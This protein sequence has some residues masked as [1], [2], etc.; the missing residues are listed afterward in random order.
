MGRGEKLFS[1][2]FPIAPRALI[3]S[4]D[5]GPGAVDAVTDAVPGEAI[6]AAPIA[7]GAG[8]EVADEDV[9]AAVAVVVAEAGDSQ[10]P[11]SITAVNFYRKMGYGFKD[12][13]KPDEEG[14][15]RMEKRK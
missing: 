9:V 11:S 1:K 7:E 14:L 10:I 5:D 2:S 8:G 4:G 3:A 12:S 13:Y 6:F 15:V